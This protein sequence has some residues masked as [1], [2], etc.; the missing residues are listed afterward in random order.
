MER[1]LLLVDDEPNVLSALRRSL[2]REGY[3]TWQAANG[4]EALQVLEHYPIDVVVSDQR[5]PLMT[6]AEFLARVSERWPHTVRLMLS[7]YNEGQAQIDNLYQGAAWKFLFKPWDDEVLRS[8]LRQAFELVET[9]ALTRR[10]QEEVAQ[11]RQHVTTMGDRML[12]DSRRLNA[13]R[14]RLDML[15]E[16]LEQLPLPCV[17]AEYGHLQLVNSAAHAYFS[18]RGMNV[19]SG[20]LSDALDLGDDW[21]RIGAAGNNSCFVLIHQ[22]LSSGTC[23]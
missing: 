11:A 21:I 15:E 2:R 18:A 4:E 16:A 6:G 22:P 10:L 14:L 13:L 17:V 7:G 9:Q 20:L 3:V 8:N 12:E 19:R 1:H 5:M 23:Q